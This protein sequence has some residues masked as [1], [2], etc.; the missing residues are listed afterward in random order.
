MG[1]EAV[2]AMDALLE[3]TAE[4]TKNREQFDQPIGK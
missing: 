2:G 4:H 1:A 3:P